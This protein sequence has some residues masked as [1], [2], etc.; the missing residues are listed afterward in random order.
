M[1]GFDS[2]ENRRRPSRPHHQTRG[3]QSHSAL[4]PL[5]PVT[6]PPTA[7]YVEYAEQRM[8]YGIL[9]ISSLFYEY[10]HLEYARVAV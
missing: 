3:T 8:K 4:T 10:I 1:L 6:G 2:G 9:F 7:L 5:K